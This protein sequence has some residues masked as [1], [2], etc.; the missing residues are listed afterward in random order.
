MVQSGAEVEHLCADGTTSAA[1]ES[2]STQSG[3]GAVAG[4]V[5]STSYMLARGCSV[6]MIPYHLAVLLATVHVSSTRTAKCRHNED[7]F[8]CKDFIEADLCLYANC[9]YV[10]MDGGYK[11]Y[12][13]GK[14]ICCFQTLAGVCRPAC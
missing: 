10:S 13:T 8:V 7:V 9:N 4:D 1:C 3:L 6:A 14:R 12:A 11:S 2:H 5:R